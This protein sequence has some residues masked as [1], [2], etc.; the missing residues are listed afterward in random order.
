MTTRVVYA[1]RM[2]RPSHSR[3]SQQSV[4]LSALIAHTKK[5]N[6]TGYIGSAADR[7]IGR[8]LRLLCNTSLDL[9]LLA[10]A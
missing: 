8:I 2:K 1:R 10:N 7:N 4:F 6:R 5:T 9:R 3:H